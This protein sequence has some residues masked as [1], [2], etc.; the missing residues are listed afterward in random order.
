[1]APILRAGNIQ[2]SIKKD[3]DSDNNTD[4]ENEID[5]TNSKT[6]EKITTLAYKLAACNDKNSEEFKITLNEYGKAR[7]NYLDDC[8]HTDDAFDAICKATEEGKKL[9][10]EKNYNE[11]I[12]NECTITPEAFEIAV[13]AEEEQAKIKRFEIGKFYTNGKNQYKVIN[14]NYINGNIFLTVEEIGGRMEHRSL[15]NIIDNV[16]TV[17]HLYYRCE[18]LKASEE[19]Q[20]LANIKKFVDS[21][22]AVD[23]KKIHVMQKPKLAE[24][25]KID[26]CTNLE[27]LK[28]KIVCTFAY[29]EQIG[30]SKTM[31]LLYDFTKEAEK[32]GLDELSKYLKFK[33]IN[34]SWDSSLDNFYVEDCLKLLA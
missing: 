9:N 10:I 31:D 13:Q 16:E 29:S 33:L 34:A 14:R 15:I 21:K 30:Y 4:S 1:M 19:V 18:I 20:Q 11:E 17:K 23:S 12:I 8:G 28:N 7:T 25:E 24:N 5:M 32:L 3:V 2:D 6:L 26:D 27:N 22:I